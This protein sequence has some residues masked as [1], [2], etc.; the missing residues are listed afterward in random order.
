[1][2]KQIAEIC[3]KEY[4]APEANNII[5]VHCREPKEIQKFKDALG[6]D[7][8]TVLIKRSNHKTEGNH[9]DENVEKFEYDFVLEN[10]STLEDF[11]QKAFEFCEKNLRSVIEQAAEKNFS[12]TN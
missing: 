3:L 7:C 9:A 1:M 10:D 12:I 8:L 6:K 11:K 2:I 4:S 5:F